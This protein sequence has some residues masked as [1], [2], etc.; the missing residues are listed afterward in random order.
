LGGRVG[1]VTTTDLRSEV[2][3]AVEQLRSQGVDV[4]QVV[5]LP[6]G[7]ESTASIPAG[8]LAFQGAQID[9][10][11]FAAPVALQSQWAALTSVVRPSTR[12]V[13]VD[14][15]DA[16][17]DEAYPTAFEGAIAVT[18][19]R[20]P[21][22]DRGHPTAMQD[23]CTKAWEAAAVPPTTLGPDEQLRV[24]QWCQHLDLVARAGTTDATALADAIRTLRA[25]SP[26][27]SDLA[28]LTGGGW[29]PAAVAE[30]QWHTSCAC[31]QPLRQLEARS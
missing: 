12:F 23:S 21:W 8:V 2:D 11:V 1:I 10:V 13:V 6:A 24:Y 19:V 31:W 29:G 25:E 26:L 15:Y 18:S 30:L 4:A 9:T 22:A 16:V 17:I 5:A 14:A 20:A 28:P 3:A 27:T 7:P